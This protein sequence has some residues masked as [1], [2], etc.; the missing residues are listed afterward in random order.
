MHK[1]YSNI[2]FYCKGRIRRHFRPL[3]C[4][5]NKASCV[6]INEKNY[7][8]VQVLT[9]GLLSMRTKYSLRRMKME[10]IMRKLFIFEKNST[11][12]E[13]MTIVEVLF[14]FSVL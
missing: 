10:I 3:V 5:L 11:E 6:K 8:L 2:E 14:I 12:S 9:L 13:K 1:V 4:F 7:D